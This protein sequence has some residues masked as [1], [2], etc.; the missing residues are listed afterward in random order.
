MPVYY[1]SG[2][3]TAEIGTFSVV[4][5][6]PGAGTAT[7]TAS[8]YAHASLASVTGTGTYTALAAAVQTALNAVVAGWTVTW[9]TSTY[10]Y[11]IAHAS[12]FTL[13]WTGDGGTNLR[14]ALG[15]SG[16]VASTTSA[17]SDVRPYYLVVSQISGRT[18][19]TDRYEPDEIV[20]EAVSD[21]GDSYAVAKDTTEGW[22]DWTQSMETKTATLLRSATSSVPWTWEHFVKHCRGTH[23]FA[24][25]GDSSAGIVYKLRAE[26]ASFSST[27]R[28]RVVS[29]YDDLWLINLRT[30]DLG[31]L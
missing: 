9:S 28:Q 27:V 22:C 14:R 31:A 16:N 15:F 26:S 25:Y 7:V 17:V 11:T 13:T 19:F 20:E 18:S 5:A 21:G 23:P 6:G 2:F 30:R 1:V 29:D 10:A 3:D 8:T 4:V 12:N 24:V